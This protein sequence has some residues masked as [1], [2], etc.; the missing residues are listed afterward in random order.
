M[1]N[2]SVHN[3]AGLGWWLYERVVDVE[4]KAVINC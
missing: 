4:V 2:W 3:L 1:E